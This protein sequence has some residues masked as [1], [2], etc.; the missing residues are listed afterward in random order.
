MYLHKGVEFSLFQLCIGHGKLSD[1]PLITRKA[2]DFF[3]KKIGPQRKKY[4]NL[5]R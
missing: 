1:F 2:R 3:L 4:E 5:E